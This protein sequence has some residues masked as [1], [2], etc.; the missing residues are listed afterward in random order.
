MVPSL[1]TLSIYHE[2]VLYP[3]WIQYVFDWDFLRKGACWRKII[4]FA[5]L[6]VEK[7]ARTIGLMTSVRLKCVLIYV[8]RQSTVNFSVSFLSLTFLSLSFLSDR[9]T[10][11]S[12]SVS[13]PLNS[14][15]LQ[16]RE[17]LTDSEKFSSCRSGTNHFPVDSNGNAYRCTRQIM[18]NAKRSS[19]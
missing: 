3:S 1:T 5:H 13:T 14:C 18:K 15:G 17:F 7:L 2:E 19:G 16:Q 8:A 11:R 4:I 12:S 6:P 10:M 9:V